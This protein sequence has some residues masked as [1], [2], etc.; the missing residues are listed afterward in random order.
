MTDFP[1]VTETPDRHRGRCAGRSSNRLFVTAAVIVANLGYEID[2]NEKKY[3]E[4]GGIV[5]D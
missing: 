3:R 2:E 4:Q 5:G 1:P